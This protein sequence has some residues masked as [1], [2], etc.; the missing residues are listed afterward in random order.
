M[1]YLALSA[2][3][4]YCKL[5]LEKYLMPK[6]STTRVNIIFYFL[7]VHNPGVNL[8]GVYLHSTKYFTR[9]ACTSLSTY[10]KL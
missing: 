3:I 7:L 4:K 5:R 10:N 2:L 9:L 8:V 6:S 1:V